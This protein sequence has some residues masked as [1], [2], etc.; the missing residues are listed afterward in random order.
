MKRFT[1]LLF[2]CL[3]M[4]ACKS[5][6]KK[7]GPDGISKEEKQKVLKDCTNFTTIEW[8]D[9]TFRD[10]GEIKRGKELEVSFRFKNTG[11]KNLVITDVT[12]SCGCT[13][14]EKPQKAF[15]P[16]EEGVIKAKFDSKR[17]PV[18][19]ARKEVHV[20]A[21]TLPSNSQ[22]LTFRVEITN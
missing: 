21:N 19:E 5:N 15:A 10:M 9:S 7:M 1:I 11:D 3:A 20:T 16:G 6:D 22:A 4:I 13:V 12:A 17:Q 8:L 14:A 18:G 2:V